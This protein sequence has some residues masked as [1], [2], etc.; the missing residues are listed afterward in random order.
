[1][2]GELSRLL[3]RNTGADC[4]PARLA[5]HW[6]SAVAHALTSPRRQLRPLARRVG[7]GTRLAPRPYLRRDEQR[8]SEHRRAEEVAGHAPSCKSSSRL[9]LLGAG[10]IY[11]VLDARELRRRRPSIKQSSPRCCRKLF[12]PRCSGRSNGT[13]NRLCPS[14]YQR[15]LFPLASGCTH[16]IR[17]SASKVA[18]TRTTHTHPPSYHR[19]LAAAA[20]R[21]SSPS[22]LDTPHRD[23]TAPAAARSS[24]PSAA[25]SAAGPHS[26]SRRRLLSTSAATPKI[27]RRGVHLSLTT[28]KSPC[29]WTSAARRSSAWRRERRKDSWRPDPRQ[30]VRS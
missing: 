7:E 9:Q 30:R 8:A 25:P 26:F 14:L 15:S 27:A 13:P 3:L 17:S 6:R 29:I 1:M 4:R 12:G 2:R 22:P 21:C 20:A 11:S 5:S 16:D 19:P 24:S 23:D 18:A 28:L 10:I